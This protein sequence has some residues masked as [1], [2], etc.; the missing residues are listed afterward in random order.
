MA[1]PG[2]AL[3]VVHGCIELN[4]PPNEEGGNEIKG[5]DSGEDSHNKEVPEN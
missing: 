3:S 4:I 1:W 5:F 2:Q